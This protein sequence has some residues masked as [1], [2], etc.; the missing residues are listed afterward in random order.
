[1]LTISVIVP[2]LDG[3]ASL[4]Q[5]LEALKLASPPVLECIVVD[6]CSSDHSPAVAEAAG[7]V[8][9]QTPRTMGPAA[10]RNLG[11]AQAS[12][13]VILFIDSDVCVHPG[14]VS[15]ILDRFQNEPGLDALIGS[16]DDQPAAPGFVSR[17][18]NLLQHYVHQNA[19][20]NATTFWSGCGAIRREVFLALGG[21]DET[22]ERPSIEDIDL[23][24]RLRGSGH[25]IAL[26]PGVQVKHLKSWRLRTMVRS[27]IFDRALPWTRLILSS[28][29]IPNDL[30]VST[31][32]RV[33]AALVAAAA[34]LAGASPIFDAVPPTLAIFPL[35]AA[36][37]I[38]H[39][40]YVFLA[41]RGG[42][43]FAVGAVVLHLAYYLYSML[44]FAAGA[45]AHAFARRQVP[46]ES[47]LT[48]TPPAPD[49]SVAGRT[50]PW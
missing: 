30:N 41:A 46:R 5:C 17:Y 45:A 47:R 34:G 20:R 2:V 35:A 28:S 4:A 29:R 21:F 37:C 19:S 10:A 38:N 13:D 14:T 15:R 23:G 26:D 27:D 1:M 49:P 6:D 39:R 44:A 25:R 32:Q 12:G 7:A 43:T 8:V 50:L 31:S 36:L 33:S 16:Y 18:K 24:Y 40:F 9:L 22:Y 3:A 11:A 48:A 42:W